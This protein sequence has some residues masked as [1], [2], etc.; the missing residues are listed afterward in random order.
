M[1]QDANVPSHRT[2]PGRRRMIWL[3]ASNVDAAYDAL[4]TMVRDAPAV[5]QEQPNHDATTQDSI[6]GACDG[7]Q[8]V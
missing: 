8:S 1:E 5:D 2:D 3:D 6:E 4:M 7:R